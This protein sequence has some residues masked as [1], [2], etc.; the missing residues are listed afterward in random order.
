[1]WN[2]FPL[3]KGS[4]LK[5]REK[6]KPGNNFKYSSSRPKEYITF[7]QLCFYTL[8]MYSPVFGTELQ[9]TALRKDKFKLWHNMLLCLPAPAEE[10]EHLCR[11]RATDNSNRSHCQLDQ[12]Y[13]LTLHC[14]STLWSLDHCWIC[15]PWDSW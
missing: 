15:F 12:I 3:H 4:S 5:Q 6:K 8:P 11:C 9:L 7:T 2:I 13:I 14:P 1:M 10:V